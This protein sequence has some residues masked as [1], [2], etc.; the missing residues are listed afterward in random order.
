MLI[1]VVLVVVVVV[2]LKPSPRIL[3][4]PQ[5]R[6]HTLSIHHLCHIAVTQYYHHFHAII[7]SLPAPLNHMIFLIIWPSH[8]YHHLTH[9]G[10]I[11]SLAS[12]TTLNA[13][14]ITP[15]QYTQSHPL[16]RHNHT[17]SIHT[18][19]SSQYSLLSPLPS[20]PHFHA[21]FARPPH[22]G[23]R[24]AG[25]AVPAR[26]LPRAVSGAGAHGTSHRRSSSDS[27]GGGGG[28]SSRQ[29]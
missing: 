6:T 29:C 24:G 1:V 14:K 12:Y 8:P 11:C 19:T 9:P 10:Q 17:L 4:V 27:S 2:W 16:N 28:M 13:I 3:L 5:V 18:L 21:R 26:P 23:P 15:S 7:P 25:G 22:H 20:S